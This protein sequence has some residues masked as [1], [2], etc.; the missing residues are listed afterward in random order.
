MAENPSTSS[1]R[2]TTLVIAPLALLEQWKSEMRKFVNKKWRI[3]IYHGKGTKMSMATM[4]Q[5]DVIIT[6]FGQIIGALPGS[7]KKKPESGISSDEEEQ[8][9]QK[10]G[11]LLKMNWYRVCVDEA[12][13]IRNHKT[14]GAKAIFQLHSTYRWILSGTLFGLNSIFVQSRYQLVILLHR[15]SGCEYPRGSV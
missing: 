8:G 14:K 6:T 4:K 3:H 11:D 9:G 12:A 2:K 5:H 13:Q 15:Y 1:K 7:K 10:K